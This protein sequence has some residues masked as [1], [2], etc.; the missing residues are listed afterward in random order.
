MQ[1]NITAFVYKYYIFYNFKN[2]VLRIFGLF[3]VSYAAIMYIQLYSPY[4]FDSID[5]LSESAFP[6][7]IVFTCS[8]V[9]VSIISII[10][11]RL[12]TLWS[13]I[14]MRAL[15]NF[16]ISVLFLIASVLKFDGNGFYR[17][18]IFW[19]CL[20]FLLYLIITPITFY[21]LLKW[22]VPKSSH[23]T[24]GFLTTFKKIIPVGGVV[25]FQAILRE[26]SESIN[27]PQLWGG[28]AYLLAI[29]TLINALYYFTQAYFAKKYSLALLSDCTDSNVRSLR[30]L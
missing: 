19:I 16:Y 24:D 22:I 18:N 28:I 3:L 12:Q 8:A 20:K 10:L 29:I 25:I 27:I 4:G 21:I 26:H 11:Y 5:L 2:L 23:K 30:H 1:K 13:F 7:T 17:E 6:Y 14:S 9:V 15:T